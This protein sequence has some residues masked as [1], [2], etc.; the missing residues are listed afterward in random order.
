MTPNNRS[1]YIACCLLTMVTALYA[2]GAVSHTPLRHLV[3]TLPLWAAMLLGFRRQ[4][5]AKWAAMPCFLV[6]LILMTFIWLFLLGWA[7]IFSGRFS[8]AEIALTLVVGAAS[9]AGLIAG[10]RWRTNV[11]WRKSLA[12]SALF[13][14]LQVAALRISFIASIANR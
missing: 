1:R 13:I 3:Q 2:V 8:P 4:P 7:R 6:W 10:M 9:L 11:T 14:V 5:A 12:L